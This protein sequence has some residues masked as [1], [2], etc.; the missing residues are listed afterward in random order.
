MTVARSLC[1]DGVILYRADECF[2]DGDPRQ[3]ADI[4]FRVR[5]S[6]TAIPCDPRY[7]HSPSHGDTASRLL[8]AAAV[9]IQLH[10]YIFI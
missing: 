8:S 6:H 4:I 9:Y 10:I 3:L 2:Y 7:T 1:C 5:G